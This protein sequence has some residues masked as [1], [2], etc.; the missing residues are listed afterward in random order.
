M[1]AAKELALRESIPCLIAAYE[2][3]FG[4]VE[5][6][7]IFCGERPKH[8]FSINTPGKPKHMPAKA[9]R[10]PVSERKP[11]ANTLAKRAKIQRITEL[12]ATGITFAEIA[13]RRSAAQVCVEHYVGAQG[14]ARACESIGGVNASLPKPRPMPHLPA[15]QR[16]LPIRLLIDAR[17]PPRWLRRVRHLLGIQGGIWRGRQGV[18]ARL[19][20]EAQG[21][22]KPEDHPAFQEGRAALI[23]GKGRDQCPYSNRRMTQ[24]HYWLGGWHDADMEQTA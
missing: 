22:N 12:A 9:I 5:T 18:L 7:P 8:V 24:R 21:M 23:E 4:P 2:A 1:D 14:A 6:T 15:P 16:P 17:T 19:S 13:E 10:K 3:E 20:P 11:R